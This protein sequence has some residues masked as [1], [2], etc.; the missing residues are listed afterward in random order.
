MSSAP[1]PPIQ[2]FSQEVQ[3]VRIPVG[4]WLL[5]FCI[6]LTILGPITMVGW[7]QKT[8]S[9]ILIAVYGSLA[10]TS[11]VAGLVTWARISSAFLWLRIALTARLLYAIFQVYFAAR[12][13]RGPS[14][15]SD[16][17]KQEIT[18]ATI[19]IFL[20]AILFFYFRFSSRV[21]KTFGRNI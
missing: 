13:A 8:S 15:N 6:S 17:V 19:N 4:G 11:F 1:P 12:A 7:M 21:Q 3:S 2:A 10:L 20:V 9:P 5:Y 16:F 18:S 14:T